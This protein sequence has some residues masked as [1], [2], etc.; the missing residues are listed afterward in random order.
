MLYTAFLTV[1]F[2]LPQN[3][4]E[5]SKVGDRLLSVPTFRNIVISL[6]STY[7]LYFLSSVLYLEPWHMLTCFVQYLLMLPTFVN[8]LMVY[9]FCNTHDVSWGT[10]GDNS[11]KDD[12]GHANIKASDDGN[13][14]VEFGFHEKG[15]KNAEYERLLD[16]LK[17][18]P[19]ET[20][21]ERE[22]HL[23]KEDYYRSFRTKMVLSWMFSNAL[24]I[25]LFTNAK[26]TTMLMG[27]MSYDED[28]NPYLTF[29]FWSVA[30]LSVFRFIGCVFYLIGRFIFG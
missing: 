9:A 24:I 30:G 2:Q 17:Q 27:K 1:Y 19:K 23:K 7:G 16:N 6:A 22:A 10:K 14:V 29:V 20:K 21:S 13:K 3:A 28:F 12:L 25:I 11:A 15:D 8:I 26:V 18:R 4:Q 5:W